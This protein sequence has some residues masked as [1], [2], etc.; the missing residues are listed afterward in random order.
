MRKEDCLKSAADFYEGTNTLVL[1][2]FKFVCI[3]VCL[4]ACVYKH[5]HVCMCVLLHKCIYMCVYIRFFVDR[6]TRSSRVIKMV[7]LSRTQYK[8][9]EVK[10]STIGCMLFLYH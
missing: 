6:I 2:N 10:N 5:V 3:Y 1:Y 9:K 4:C 8:D 7:V